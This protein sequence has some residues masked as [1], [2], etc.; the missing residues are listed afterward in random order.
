MAFASRAVREFSVLSIALGQFRLYFG[1]Q[2]LCRNLLSVF[3]PLLSFHTAKSVNLK[4]VGVRPKAIEARPA[5]ERLPGNRARS[6]NSFLPAVAFEDQGGEIIRFG[7]DAFFLLTHQRGGRPGLPNFQVEEPC[8]LRAR[9]LC[10]VPQS[11][12]TREYGESSRGFPQA[13]QRPF[14]K[15]RIFHFRRRSMV[16]VGLTSSMHRLSHRPE[17]MSSKK[18]KIV[19]T[20]SPVT[21]R[22]DKPTRAPL[23][24]RAER[25]IIFLKYRSERGSLSHGRREPLGRH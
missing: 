21:V 19:L 16:F 23:G 10:F 13:V 12:Q 3:D 11:L 15:R 24:S 2:A 7:H 9:S 8:F 1:L 17:S 25:L 18:C 6:V 20:A 5:R 4:G 22:S 14:L